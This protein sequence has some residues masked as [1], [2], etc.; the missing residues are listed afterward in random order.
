VEVVAEVVVTELRVD[1][2]GMEAVEE[3]PGLYGWQQVISVW[4]IHWS[5]L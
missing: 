2:E 4:V 5:Q 1:M 3:Q